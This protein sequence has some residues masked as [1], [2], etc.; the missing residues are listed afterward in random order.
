[1]YNLKQSVGVIGVYEYMSFKEEG[2]TSTLRIFPLKLVDKFVYLG[3][4]ITS[5]KIDVSI[6][7]GDTKNTTDNLLIIWESVLYD[8]KNEIS[9]KL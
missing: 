8:K 2:A 1:M 5:T 9:F 6:H 3:S 7:L 4:N